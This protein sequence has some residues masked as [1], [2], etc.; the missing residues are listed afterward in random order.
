MAERYDTLVEDP[1]SQTVGIVHAA[2]VEDAEKLAELLKKNRP[3]RDILI[4]GYEPVTGSHVG[5][6][7][8][9][10]FFEGR[11]DVRTALNDMASAKD[12]L[13]TMVNSVKTTLD[14]YKGTSPA[15]IKADLKAGLNTARENMAGNVKEKLDAVRETDLDDVKE[16][17]AKAKDN[18]AGKVNSIAVTEIAEVKEKL[19]NIKESIRKDH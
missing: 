7:T 12:R 4:V 19:E 17:L 10:L 18:V 16:A 9:A 8:L 2:C 14:S 6:G 11:D 5:P 13:K 15:E 1:A 3:P